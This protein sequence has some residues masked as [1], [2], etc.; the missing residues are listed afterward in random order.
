[1][2]RNGLPDFGDVTSFEPRRG[3]DRRGHPDFTLYNGPGAARDPGTLRFNHRKHLVSTGVR[4]PGQSEPAVLDCFD[5]HQPEADRRAM[6]PIRY[7]KHCRDCHPINV[8][9]KL[10]SDDQAVQKAA[11]EFALKPVSHPRAGESP[12]DVRAGIRERLVEFINAHPAAT[13]GN[14]AARPAPRPIPG[15]RPSVEPP[16]QAIWDWVSTQLGGCEKS[17]FREAQGCRYCHAIDGE[18]A[19]GLPIYAAP[20][21]KARWL[22]HASFD[23]DSHRGFGCVRCHSRALTSQDTSEILLPHVDDCMTCHVLGVQAARSDCVECHRYHD[24]A[25]ERWSRN[26][27]TGQK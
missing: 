21:V 11:D 9:L 3:S 12:A 17:L 15:Q 19:D 6:S 25:T 10:T 16:D 4:V 24:R 27:S 22:E 18:K 20:G 7:E 2:K 5:C 26:P 23:H 1:M 14:A 8:A 13:S